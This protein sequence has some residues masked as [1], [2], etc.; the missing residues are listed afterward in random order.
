MRQ[1]RPRDTAWC[2]AT[3]TF[4]LLAL[5]GCVTGHDGVDLVTSVALNQML[6]GVP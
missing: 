3:L 5:S 6:W 2:W 1:M 4:L